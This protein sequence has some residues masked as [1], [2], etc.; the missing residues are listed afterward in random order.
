VTDVIEGMAMA[1]ADAVNKDLDPFMRLSNEGAIAA[2]KA[3]MDYLK[4]EQPTDE[5]RIE[6]LK[7]WF[8][9]EDTP[10]SKPLL[11]GQG[12]ELNIEQIR[13]MEKLP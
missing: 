8:A 6:A 2:A 4:Q 1:I 3:A 11:E 10:A 12:P 7:A 5:Q 13:A 9:G